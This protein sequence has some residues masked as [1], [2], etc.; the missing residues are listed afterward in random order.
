MAFCKP[1]ADKANETISGFVINGCNLPA[2]IN[3][4]IWWEQYGKP[5]TI[6]KIKNL[7]NDK[8]KGIKETFYGK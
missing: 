3:P 6:E 2:W 1:D 8:I 7:R 5:I 4:S